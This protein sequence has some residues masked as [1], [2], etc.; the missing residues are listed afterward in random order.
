MAKGSLQETTTQ[1]RQSQHSAAIKQNSLPLNT[2]ALNLFRENLNASI[3]LQK[4]PHKALDTWL[5][6]QTVA[7]HPFFLLS[8]TAHTWR[9]RSSSM[10]HYSNGNDKH[11]KSKHFPPSALYFLPLHISSV[12]DIYSFLWNTLAH[13]CQ[14]ARH[15]HWYVFIP[16]PTYFQNRYTRLPMAT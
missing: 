15:C 14:S 1:S 11:V 12:Y 4:S 13:C 3:H 7:K 8:P 6:V 5:V 10:L 16:Q 2:T 9:Y